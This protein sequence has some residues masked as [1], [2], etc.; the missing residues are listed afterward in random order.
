MVIAHT[1]SPTFHIFKFL[2]RPLLSVG[3]KSDYLPKGEYAI[4]E[5]PRPS[6]EYYHVGDRV[7]Y[8]CQDGYTTK[9]Y[10]QLVVVCLSNSSWKKGSLVCE[11]KHQGEY[12]TF[13]M[14][15]R[16]VK[17]DRTVI[18]PYLLYLTRIKGMIK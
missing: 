1:H 2:F 5:R 16:A 8:K 12:P 4:P 3:C 9:D 15:G 17:S 7:Q 6:Y 11:K 10:S 13:F 18:G 14:A